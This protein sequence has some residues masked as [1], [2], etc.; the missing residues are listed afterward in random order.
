MKK[1]KFIRNLS[2]VLVSIFTIVVSLIIVFTI[3]G[4][5]NVYYDFLFQKFKK[6][7]ITEDPVIV[8]IDQNTLNYFR[9]NLQ[10]IWPWPRD[11]YQPIVDY[12]SY[13]GASVISF[14][15]LFTSPGIDRMNIGGF[16][17]D[18]LFAKSMENSQISTLAMQFEDSTLS[19]S[20]EL[21]NGY[22]DKE[23][24]LPEK[25][26]HK[27]S[28]ASLPIP[29]FQKSAKYLGAVNIPS[30]SSGIIRKLPL[31]FE[32]QDKLV[33]HLA[34]STYMIAND[35][36]Q[37]TYDDA[38]NELIAGDLRI[39]LNKEGDYLIN[40]YGKGG[41]DNSF[42]YYS[43]ANLLTSSVQWK[44]G[45]K[46]DIMPDKLTGKTVF[47]GAVAAGLLDMKST[48][49]SLGDPYPGIEIYT[50]MFRNFQ[51]EEFIRHFPVVLWI[52]ILV[53]IFSTNS[54]IWRS[55][56]LGVA[57][58]TSLL[59]LLVP[60]V[61]SIIL[62]R[63]FS[64]LF[65]VV[66]FESGLLLN[67]VLS[68]LIEYF[69]AGRR[70]RKLRKNFSRYLEPRLVKMIADSPDAVVT[71]GDEVV[72]TVLF[73]DIKDF[74]KMSGMLSS[75][76]I[77]NILNNYFE[78]GEKIIFK[79]HGMLDK[80]TGDGLMALFGI[81]VPNQDHAIS[82]CNAIIDFGQLKNVKLE[83]G[84]KMRLQTRVGVHTGPLVAG[85]IGSS[86]R[87]DYTAI[88][89]TVN[90]AARLEQLNKIFNTTNIISAE[91]CDLVNRNF[92]YRDLD[93]YKV[94]GID[95]ALHIFT[96]IC[97]KEEINRE[98]KE[99]LRL[100]N[101]GLRKMRSGDTS[102]AIKMFQRIKREFPEDKVVDYFIKKCHR[103]LRKRGSK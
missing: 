71:T 25:I 74:T 50:T 16:Y 67:L 68:I 82:A 36:S 20:D 54:G 58:I 59:L 23:N 52:I 26:F 3:D 94:R 89:S 17:S 51:N 49:V 10:I 83:N 35:V 21:H 98:I 102:E 62:F 56:K 46:P 24:E 53:I 4:S 75:K 91:T 18:S 41:V 55:E 72:A 31:L 40:W 37:L 63:H 15:I 7:E 30:T 79:N 5:E 64:L 29:M 78:E 80:Y 44:R 76:K 38:K 28:K 77:V 65:P 12:L 2:P 87:V 73:S 88:G 81:P 13:C 22:L 45:L 100:H 33:P 39:P 95:K 99:M 60:L 34:L 14:D 66:A 1:N 93:Y 90:I 103:R 47:I 86:R 57:T 42:K 48:P 8:A 97:R 6:V 70:N 9:N 32:Y 61:I 43:F 11:I 85:N 84:G 27:F 96:V 101:Q 92:V 19:D 69:W